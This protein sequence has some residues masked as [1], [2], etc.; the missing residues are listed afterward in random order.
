MLGLESLLQGMLAEPN[1]LLFFGL[2]FVFIL[3]AYKAVKVL[4]RAL[5]VAAIAGFFPV[6]ANM[7]LGFSFEI[8]IPNIIRFAMMG[9]EMYFIYHILVSIGKIVEFVLKPF[10]GKKV[11]KVEKVI[12]ME[13]E[14]EKDDKKKD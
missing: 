2:F 5:I 13:K 8:T 1:S 4:F 10:T 6:F 14:R 9:A 7:F 11:K 3:L 12:I